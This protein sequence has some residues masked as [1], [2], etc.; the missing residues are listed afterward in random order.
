MTQALQMKKAQGTEDSED[1][2]NVDADVGE[3]YDVTNLT[4]QK[5]MESFQE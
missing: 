4:K 5:K 1:D 3:E 2:C